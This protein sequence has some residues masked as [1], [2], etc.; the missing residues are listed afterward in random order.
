[1]DIGERAENATVR[2]MMEEINLSLK[3]EDLKQFHVYSDPGRDK[4][5]HTVSVVFSVRVRDLSGMKRG[6][7]AK[8]VVVVSAGRI[9]Q[10]DM[11]FDHKKVLMDYLQSR[12]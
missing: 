5:R 10:L 3:M 2:E 7:D 11:A 1:M 8:E 6:S 9:A 4:R 12:P